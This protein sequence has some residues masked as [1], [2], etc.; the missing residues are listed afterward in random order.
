MRDLTD[1]ER[2]ERLY[3]PSPAEWIEFLEKKGIQEQLEK[4]TQERKPV[5]VNPGGAWHRCGG[6]V[7][8]RIEWP[9]PRAVNLWQLSRLL[10]ECAIDEA[11]S[12]DAHGIDIGVVRRY[13]DLVRIARVVGEIRDDEGLTDIRLTIGYH[14]GG[15][16]DGNRPVA[17]RYMAPCLDEEEEMVR[18]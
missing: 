4:G 1:S 12:W 16:A 8:V 14:A 6:A 2:T 13:E 11:P 18:G 7:R 5:P 15:D 3:V 17:W 10:K 9:Y